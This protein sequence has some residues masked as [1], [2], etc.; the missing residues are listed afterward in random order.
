MHYVWILKSSEVLRDEK[1]PGGSASSVHTH[2]HITNKLCFSDRQAIR[3]FLIVKTQFDIL[4]SELVYLYCLEFDG[5]INTSL[6][7]VNYKVGARIELA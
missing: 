5:K 7:F 2:I 6:M 4:D 3:Q 1:P